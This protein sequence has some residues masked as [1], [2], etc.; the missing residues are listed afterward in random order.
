MLQNHTQ[1]R[2]DNNVDSVVNFNFHEDK[3][4]QQFYPHSYHGVDKLGRPIYV[5]QVGLLNTAGFL[6]VSSLERLQTHFI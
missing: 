6:K 5:E 3:L 4:V 2:K 1:W